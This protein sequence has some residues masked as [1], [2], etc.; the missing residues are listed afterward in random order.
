M[1]SVRWGANPQ[2]PRPSGGVRPD[3]YLIVA[4]GQRLY[5]PAL[6]ELAEIAECAIEAGDR[7]ER[8]RAQTG[9]GW[10]PLGGGEFGRFLRLLA[11]RIGR[12][13]P[14]PDDGRRPPPEA[15]EDL[16]RPERVPSPSSARGS[17]AEGKPPTPPAG[18]GPLPQS[19]T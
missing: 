10:R 11:A 15:T 14:T 4:A 5:A 16:D 13:P 6:D 9:E 18:D 7:I 19:T 3:A 12:R 8:L 2:R 17:R 1:G